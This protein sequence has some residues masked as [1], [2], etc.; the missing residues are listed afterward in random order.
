MAKSMLE[1]VVVRKMANQ[2]R[3]PGLA[4]AGSGAMKEN[5]QEAVTVPGWL[6]ILMKRKEAEPEAPATRET[7]QTEMGKVIRG[8]K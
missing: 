7:N 4:T 8:D 1:T 2:A 5:A 6:L 3:T